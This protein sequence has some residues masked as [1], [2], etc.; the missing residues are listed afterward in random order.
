MYN[1]NTTKNIRKFTIVDF[2]EEGK[3]YGTFKSTIPKKAANEAFDLL[4]RFIDNKNNNNKS[5]KKNKNN[6]KNS[7][8]DEFKGKFIVFVIK[9]IDSGKMYKYIGNRVKLHKPIKINNKSYEY[10]NVIGKY[11]PELDLI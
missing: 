1:N 10:K 3:T 5:N 4:I 9:D 7:N 6:N 11:N 8:N 2:P